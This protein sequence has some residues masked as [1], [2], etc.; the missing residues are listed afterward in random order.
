MDVIRIIV[1]YLVLLNLIGLGIMGLDKWKATYHRWRIPETHLF[2]VALMGG[3]LG[4]FVGMHVFHHKT[5]HWYFRYGMPVIL[6]AQLIL[7]A[8]LIGSDRIE[9][10]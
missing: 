2:L 10:M 1:I 7:G 8:Y 6:A 3:S 9:I 5:R 4:T